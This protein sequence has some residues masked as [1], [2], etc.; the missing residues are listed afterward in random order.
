MDQKSVCEAPLI[1]LTYDDVSLTLNGTEVTLQLTTPLIK[2]WFVSKDMDK[3]NPNKTMNVQIEFSKYT[4][5]RGMYSSWN[6]HEASI[7]F[8]SKGEIIKVKDWNFTMPNNT[9]LPIKFPLT[10][11][12]PIKRVNISMQWSSNQIYPFFELIGCSA[13]GKKATIYLSLCLV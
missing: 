3:I 10:Y 13:E 11:T 8:E 12:V 1:S 2:R 6:V 5:L 7:G 9:N 4:I